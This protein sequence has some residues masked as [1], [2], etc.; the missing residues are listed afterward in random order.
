MT[1]VLEE[2]TDEEFGSALEKEIR[3]LLISPFVK[4]SS[5]KVAYLLG[6][7]SGAGKTMLHQ[8]IKEMLGGNV[9][10]I[11]GDE[12]RSDHP[13]FDAI[14][15]RYGI[16]APAHT[17]AWSGAMVEALVDA[18]SRAG[19]N[20]VVEGT[21]RTSEVPF[22]TERLLR[23]RG[24]SVSL[25]IMAV[26]PQISLASCQLRCEQM[27]V[28]GTTPRATDPAHHNKIIHDIVDNLAVLEDS[29]EFDEVL[30]Y[31]RSKTRLYPVEGAQSAHA[32]LQE[33]L[34]GQLTQQEESH[35]AYLQSEI[36]RCKN[37]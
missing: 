33:V 14:Q 8:V 7:Q 31:N 10:V 29:G 26:K 4:P 12:F 37:M 9:V 35:L 1:N 30:L 19:Y 32:V 21:L 23:K 28:A 2:Y 24:Y 13:R 34:F 15:E 20:L 36:E 11:N 22:K 18:L 17:A 3:T 16:D 6:G 27:R 25:A 5:D